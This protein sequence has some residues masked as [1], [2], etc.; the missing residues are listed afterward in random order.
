MLKS[1]LELV[2]RRARQQP[3]RI[4]F[5][6]TFDERTIKAIERIRKEGTAVPIIIDKM[7]EDAKLRKRYAEALFD[8]RK[9]KGMTLDEA[10]KLMKDRNYF[11]VMTVKIGEADGLI[12]GANCPS[13]ET[14][15]PALQIIKTKEKFHKVSGFFFMVLGNKLLL[16]ADCMV[17]IEPNSHE[18]MEI[19]IDSAETAKRFGIEPRIAML[20]FSTN[21]SAKH[22]S[23]DRVREA[24]QMIRFHRPDLICDGEM[25][26]DAALVPDVC[27]RK[28]P[29]SRVPGN[30]NVLIFPDLN[31]ANISYKLVERLAKAQAIGPI[32]QGLQKPVNDLSR[33]CTVDDIVQLAAITSVEVQDT[34]LILI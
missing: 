1:F 17:N 8:L 16:F 30:A 33:G 13:H 6:E 21:G 2:R 15:R 27:A 5:P 4:V 10:M 20:S 12:S 34:P 18:L 26:V 32:L 24:T 19:A 7:M 25:Q 22:P 3:A 14:L 31:S 11:G 23:V 29:D 28:F 9:D